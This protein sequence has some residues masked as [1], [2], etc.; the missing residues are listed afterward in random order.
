MSFNG[1]VYRAKW[2]TRGIEP[3]Q[4]QAFEL[5]SDVLLNYDSARVYEAGDRA[6]YENGVYEAKWW[7]RG[8]APGTDPWRYVGEK[9]RCE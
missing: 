5:I 1:L 3:P 2:W 4:S 8:S 7:T 6:I 9:P